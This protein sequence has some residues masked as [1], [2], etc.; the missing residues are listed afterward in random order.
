MGGADHGHGGAGSPG[1]RAPRCASVLP[2]RQRGRHLPAGRSQAEAEEELRQL[3]AAAEELAG[4]LRA[5]RSWAEAEHCKFTDCATEVATL[6][7]MAAREFRE[8]QSASKQLVADIKGLAQKMGDLKA[9][10]RV[11]RDSVRRL[12]G[13][14]EDGADAPP[15]FPRLAADAAEFQKLALSVKLRAFLDDAA[16]LWLLAAAFALGALLALA[17]VGEAFGGRGCR[18]VCAR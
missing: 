9:A 15:D 5:A 3:Q 11:L 10:A 4:K 8:R 17:V 6:R 7:E 18:L 1:W 16:V 12:G 13:R 14:G 2:R